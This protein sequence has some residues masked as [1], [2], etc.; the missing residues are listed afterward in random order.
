MS[1]DTGEWLK[2]N[3]NEFSADSRKE[4]RKRYSEISMK[5]VE[6]PEALAI[7]EFGAL[8]EGIAL[9]NLNQFCRHSGKEKVTLDDLFLLHS[10]NEGARVDVPWHVA[11]FFTNKAKGYKKKI[12]I[13]GA[14][15]IGRIARSYGLMT[16]G[17]LR[18]VT[19]GLETLLLNDEGAADVGN[20][21]EGGVRHRSNMSFTN[22]LKAMDERLGEMKINIFK[23]GSDVD[24]LTYIV[25]GISEQYN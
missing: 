17:S 4:F 10:M 2:F 9:L 14:R 18:N 8:H 11:K 15:L 1:Q 22:R 7:D 3:N 16:H 5:E 20:D 6:R 19:L 24:D 23:L 13:V 12:L 25:S 21:D